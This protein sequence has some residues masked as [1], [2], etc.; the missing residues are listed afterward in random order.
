[1]R[2]VS[3]QQALAAAIRTL[4]TEKCPACLLDPQGTFLFVNEAWDRQPLHG[5]GVPAGP[6]ASLIGTSWLAHVGSDEVRR[7]HAELLASALEPGRPRRALMQ[8][9]ESNTATTATLVSTR[10]EPVTLGGAEALGVKVVHTLAR[11]RPIEEVYELVHLPP[12]SYLDAAGALRQ[13]ACC[14][15]LGH[16][17]DPGRW[18]LVPEAV[19]ALAGAQQVLC[20]LCAEL[21]F[22]E[23]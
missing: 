21:H 10:F 4:S 5:P 18:D 3:H 14:G 12:E 8:V 17:S 23:P 16:P 11:S 1:M 22:V 19:E 2:A 9:S 6:G 13:C 15:R 20:D 7:R